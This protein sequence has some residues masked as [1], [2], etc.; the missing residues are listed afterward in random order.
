MNEIRIQF[1]VDRDT[2][3]EMPWFEAFKAYLL[4]SLMVEKPLLLKS[5]DVLRF[6]LN[7]KN[8]FKET[9]AYS[10]TKISSLD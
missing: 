5:D 2:D 9:E 3:R 6:Y 8:Y 7:A 10:E 1:L 4:F